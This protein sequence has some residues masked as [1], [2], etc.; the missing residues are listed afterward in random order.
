M[1]IAGNVTNFITR[2]YA[3]HSYRQT[4]LHREKDTRDIMRDKNEIK[5]A[6][7]PLIKPDIHI[8]IKLSAKLISFFRSK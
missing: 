1:A 5:T 8:K 4:V 3:I 6:I 2:R 7:F